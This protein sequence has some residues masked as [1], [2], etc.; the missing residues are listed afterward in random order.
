LIFS[1]F[2]EA[3]EVDPIL[4]E[5]HEGLVFVVLDPVVS[6]PRLQNADAVHEEGCFFKRGQPFSGRKSMRTG[7]C[8]RVEELLSRRIC[9]TL[10][11]LLDPDP[12]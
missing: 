7:G 9:A 10:V 8:F 11:D 6:P 4:P 1:G 2:I 5:E 3:E 12:P